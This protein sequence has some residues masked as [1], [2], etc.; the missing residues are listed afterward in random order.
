MLDFALLT[1]C[2]AS[3]VLEMWETIPNH[4]WNETTITRTL[5]LLSENEQRGMHFKLYCK[6]DIGVLQ[7]DI[8]RQEDDFTVIWKE[9]RC[10]SRIKLNA[11]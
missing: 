4:E 1:P 6:I 10:V 8:C 3:I 2:S 9:N 5:K 7:N 11:E